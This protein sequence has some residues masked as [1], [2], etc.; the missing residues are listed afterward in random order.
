M[1]MLLLAACQPKAP[2]PEPAVP[3]GLAGP[4]RTI[5]TMDTGTVGG[6]PGD[7][8]AVLSLNLRCLELEGTAFADS[9]DRF[10]AI[11]ATVH[12]EAVDVLALQ[13]VC[14]RG[15]IDALE[16]LRAALASATG[17]AWQGAFAFAHVAWEGT[18]DEADEGVGLLSRRG[19][20]EPT[21]L[22]YADPGELRRVALCATLDDGTTVA[23]VHLDHGRD[24]ARL[25]QARQTASQVLAAA[26]SLD[27]VVAGDFNARAGAPAHDVMSSMGYRD[28]SEALAADRIDHAFVH[29]GSRWVAEGSELWFVDEPVSDHPGVFVALRAADPEPVEV[30]RIVAHVDVGFGHTLS[31]RGDAAPL[32]WDDGWWAWPAAADR[33]ELVLTELDAPFVYKTL[34]DDVSWQ[35]GDDVAGEPGVD[36]ETAPSF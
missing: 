20:A 2:A 23:S 19:L 25:D 32:S 15:E 27:V 33:W 28:A 1:W 30:T 9:T 8:L 16:Q 31:V 24:D 35:V 12:A 22:V 29:R 13:E 3:T 34:V 17:D 6:A 5:D 10:A 4:D 11:A 14:R 21:E 18:A 36:N 26:P 7:R